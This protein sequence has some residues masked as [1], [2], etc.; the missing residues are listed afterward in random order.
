MIELVSANKETDEHDEEYWHFSITVDGIQLTSN[1][2][3]NDS[4]KTQND[5]LTWLS[6]N[7]AELKVQAVEFK[8]IDLFRKEK[9]FEM[10]WDVKVIEEKVDAMKAEP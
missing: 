1:V 3:V 6:N 2:Y 10:W 4:G 9:V 5:L 8:S 7:E